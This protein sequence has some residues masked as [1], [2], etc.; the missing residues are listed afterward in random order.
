[1]IEQIFNFYASF[2]SESRI[3]RNIGYVGLTRNSA[4]N[5]NNKIGLLLCHSQIEFRLRLRLRLRMIETEVE[6]RLSSG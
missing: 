4:L 6:L 2:N 5:L 1:M 3:W